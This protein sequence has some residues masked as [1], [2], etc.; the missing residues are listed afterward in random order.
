M[1]CKDL[2]RLSREGEIARFHALG[3]D[4]SGGGAGSFGGQSDYFFLNRKTGQWLSATSAEG[5]QRL[6]D[7][8]GAR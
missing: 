7:R 2:G 3:G 6:V 5:L 1:G 8:L 4:A